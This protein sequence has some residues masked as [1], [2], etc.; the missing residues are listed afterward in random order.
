VIH[1]TKHLELRVLELEDTVQLMANI[2]GSMNQMMKD[3]NEITGIHTEMIRNTGKALTVVPRA[4]SLWPKEGQ[5]CATVDSN[6]PWTKYP[7]D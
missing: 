3:L 2:I 1:R 4:L 6:P 5:E 7:Q